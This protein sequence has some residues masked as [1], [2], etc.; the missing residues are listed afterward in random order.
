MV[1]L[2]ASLMAER[3]RQ[4]DKQ[5]R[6]RRTDPLAQ[7]ELLAHK[8]THG[9]RLA[10]GEIPS[11]AEIIER[12]VSTITKPSNRA[13]SLFPDALLT[14]LKPSS[15]ALGSRCRWCLTDLY[16]RAHNKAPL[17]WS[18]ANQVLLGQPCEK[19]ALRLSAAIVASAERR[20]HRQRGKSIVA[21]LIASGTVTRRD[22]KGRPVRL[23][24][25]PA[26]T[27]AARCDGHCSCGCGTFHSAVAAATQAGARTFVVEGNTWQAASTMSYHEYVTGKPIDYSKPPYNKVTRISPFGVERER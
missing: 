15:T 5:A 21:A 10:D 14:A 25:A 19:C 23:R 11:R 4:R 26:V 12:F 7:A 6:A 2:S 27:A 16:A 1:D 18:K 24:T 22:R 17:P 8:L 20:E 3:L 9:D 13:E